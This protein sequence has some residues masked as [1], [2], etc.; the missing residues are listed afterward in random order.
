MVNYQLT[1]GSKFLVS[2]KNNIFK[3]SGFV[4]EPG[5]GSVLGSR[6]ESGLI[7]NPILVLVPV[8]EIRLGCDLIFTNRNHNRWF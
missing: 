5:P 4:P 1:P 7:L 6:T 8:P 3:T 2:Q